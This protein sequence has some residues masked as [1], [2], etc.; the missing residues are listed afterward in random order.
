MLQV[1]PR[2]PPGIVNYLDSEIASTSTYWLAKINQPNNFD[3]PRTFRPPKHLP[4]VT[5]LSYMLGVEK[6]QS[7]SKTF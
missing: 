2:F 6:T 3:R 1:L 4:G 7:H 5:A